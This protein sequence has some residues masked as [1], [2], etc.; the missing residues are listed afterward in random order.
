M[1]FTQNRPSILY[2]FKSIKTIFKNGRFN[3]KIND[4]LNE[5]SGKDSEWNLKV[6]INRPKTDSK[7]QKIEFTVIPHRIWI[8]KTYLIIT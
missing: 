2:D 3:T 4:S 8:K 1:I 6:W 7:L 5:T